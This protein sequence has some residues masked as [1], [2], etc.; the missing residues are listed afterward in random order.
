M[1]WLQVELTLSGELAE[2]VAEVLSRYASGGVAVTAADDGMW[3][4]GQGAPVVV[5]AF[6]PNDSQL[7]AQ[8]TKIEEGLWHLS[9]IQPLPEA[10]FQ[11]VEEANWAEAWKKR[12]RPIP[13]GRRLLIQPAWQGCHEG[14][15]IVVRVDPGMAFGTGT[16]PTTRHCLTLLE[17]HLRG[18]ETVV[19]LGSGS[20][21]LSIAA[22]KLGCRRALAYDIS[23]SALSAGRQ[24]AHLNA[25]GDSI[26]FRAGSLGEV[27]A[28]VEKGLRPDIVVVNILASVIESM[29]TAGL[30]S[31]VPSG[32]KLILAG[33][34]REQL[35]QIESTA[36]AHGLTVADRRSEDDWRSLLLT[37]RPSLVEGR[38]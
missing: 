6:L 2:P 28:A 7:A 30:A 34:L 27:M 18:G 17:E 11:F 29:L 33:I 32:G 5:R 36:R 3:E 31:V 38:A 23:D 10:S 12:Y 22:V 21:I 16:H 37:N 14:E 20:G 24:N 9:Q 8:R 25:V 1:K 4:A 35:A 13:I 15:R 19:D 26:E